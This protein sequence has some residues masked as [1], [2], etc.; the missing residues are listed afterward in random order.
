MEKIL[1]FILLGIGAVSDYRSNRVSNWLCLF[2]GIMGL[3]L[4][5]KKKGFTGIEDII[6]G[7]IIILGILLPLWFLHIIGGGDV[8]LMMMTSCYLGFRV[9][10][11]LAISA[12]FSAIYAIFLLVKRKNLRRRMNLLVVY[13]RECVLQGAIRVYPFDKDERVD[14]EDGGIHIS[15][16]ILAGYVIRLLIEDFPGI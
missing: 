14:R 8:K 12:V 11:L 1:L 4:T 10:K 6:T 3:L 7:M 5:W 13:C 2:G 9:W 16:A 15:Y